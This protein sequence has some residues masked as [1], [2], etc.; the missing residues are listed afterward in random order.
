MIWF[1]R[2]RQDI[3][4]FNSDLDRLVVQAPGSPMLLPTGPTDLTAFAAS[5]N[6]AEQATWVRPAYADNLL[7]TLLRQQA[8][9][10]KLQIV[11]TESE[12]L[13]LLPVPQRVDIRHRA[14]WL[15]IAAVL[16]LATAAIGLLW[17]LTR[18]DDDHIVIAPTDVPGTPIASPSASSVSLRWSAVDDSR[19]LRQPTGLAVAPDGTICVID[20]VRSL[21]RIYNPDG[22]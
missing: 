16:V 8:I 17:Q 21:I 11:P 15:R 5:L 13:E 2:N 22:T 9:A 19:Q 1:P 3:D 12:S 7:E 4:A 18:P 6:V 10:P 20:T 14:I